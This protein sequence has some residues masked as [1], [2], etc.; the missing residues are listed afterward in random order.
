[1]PL[2]GINMKSYKIVA[3][4]ALGLLSTVDYASAR[5]SN[6]SYNSRPYR[7]YSKPSYDARPKTQLV[8]PYVKENGTVVNGYWRRPKRH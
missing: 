3:L 2:E 4:I 6:G 7:S 8:R 1:M 5:K